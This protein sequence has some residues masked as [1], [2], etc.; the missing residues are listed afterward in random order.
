ML[1]SPRSSGPSSIS[2]SNAEK[3]IVLT[4]DAHLELLGRTTENVVGQ[5]WQEWMTEADYD[6]VSILFARFLVDLKPFGTFTQVRRPDGRLI[7]VTT[8]C[9]AV[10]G[11]R[12]GS[13]L[14]FCQMQAIDESF[15]ER[16]DK[17]FQTAELVRD[18]TYELAALTARRKL[19]GLTDAL[20]GTSGS[21]ETAIELMARAVASPKG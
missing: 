16:D 10:K 15:G 9:S 7:P 11:D 18:V 6:A 13:D 14:L 12:P 21:A 19:R 8:Q 3:R 1:M 2:I 5:T 4:S 20:I 17:R